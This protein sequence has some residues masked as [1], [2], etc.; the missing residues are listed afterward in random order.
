MDQ[1]ITSRSLFFL[2]RWVSETKCRSIRLDSKY[3]YPLSCLTGS[4]TNFFNQTLLYLFTGASIWAIC[5]VWNLLLFSEVTSLSHTQSSPGFPYS[6][7][8]PLLNVIVPRAQYLDLFTSF[9]PW[10]WA[11]AFLS[12]NTI[13][14]LI[15]RTSPP[16]KSLSGYFELNMEF[17]PPP[18]RPPLCILI[19]LRRAAPNT[20]CLEVP[21]SHSWHLISL[22][23]LAFSPSVSPIGATFKTCSESLCPPKIN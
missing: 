12:L 4:H 19:C 10:E 3:L 16:S 18:L 23:Q 5:R 6:S 8:L 17:S 1:S 21:W 15:T 13:Y 2:N 11:P 20:F 14:M 22:L 9:F 7:F